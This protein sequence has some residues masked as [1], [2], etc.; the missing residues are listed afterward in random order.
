MCLG[1]RS[2]TLHCDHLASSILVHRFSRAARYHLAAVQSSYRS[3][4]EQRYCKKRPLRA[5][6]RE[7]LLHDFVS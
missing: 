1:K 2:S 7:M 6:D 3:D 5:S 4:Q